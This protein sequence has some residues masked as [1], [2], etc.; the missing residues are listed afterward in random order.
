MPDLNFQVEGV[1]PQ[2]FAAAPLL[3]FK[4]RIAEGVS[5]G[6]QPTPIHTIVLR[7]QIRIE[8]ARRRYSAE[9]QRRLVDLFGTPERWGQTLRPMLWT[10]VSAVVPPFTGACAVDL[11]VPCSYDF[12][13]AATKYFA[14][15][16]EDGMPLCFLF[17]GTI[18]YL[19][20]EDALQV[21]QISWEKE[22][23]FRLPAQTWR[24]MM[25][26]HYPNS[27]WLCLR[28]DVFDSLS[29]YKSRQGLP[30]WEQALERLLSAAEE[31]VKP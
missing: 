13:L 16:E 9:E 4:L 12:S 19:A 31:T 15:L 5:P 6:R 11:P 28:K 18:F 20:D 26:M 24:G 22:A 23:Y 25:E 17:S 27:A 1:E 7:C 8:P 10:H 21:E 2:R 3:L 30:T 14:A 29:E